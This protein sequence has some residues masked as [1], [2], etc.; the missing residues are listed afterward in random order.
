MLRLNR[1]LFALDGLLLIGVALFL[2]AGMEAVPFHGDESTLIWLS[3]D[4]YTIVHE[5]NPEAVIFRQPPLDGARQWNRVMTGAIAP[6]T[7]GLAW[8]V[9]GFTPAD[10]N[11]PWD[12]ENVRGMT[13]MRWTLNERA[14]AL[15][16]PELLRAARFP[17]TLFTAL[18]A[19]FLLAIV[20]TLTRELPPLIRHPAAWTA[21]LLYST[22]PAVLVNGRRAMQEGAMLCFTALVILVALQ[23]IR[24]IQ[25]PRPTRRR[26][27]GWLILLGV[28][29][30]AAMASKHTSALAF[31]LALL[32]VGLAPL[33][34]RWRQRVPEGLPLNRAHVFGVIG[35]GCLG[36]LVFGLLMPVWWFGPHLLV[37]AGLT[38]IAFT[39]SLGPAGLRRWLPLGA[40][41]LAIFAAHDA[42]PRV[43]VEIIGL[44]IYL[45][46]MRANLIA[47]QQGQYLG[48]GDQPSQGTILIEEAFFAPAE[49]YEDPTWAVFET[50]TAQIAAYEASG[51]AGV[52]GPV[53]GAILIG[54]GLAGLA[55]GL[56]RWRDGGR[57]LIAL[58]L[59]SGA[60]VMFFTPLPWQR[61]YLILHAPLAALAGPG[62][63]A[64]LA[65]AVSL[66]RPAA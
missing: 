10:L 65:G 58:W 63:A 7:M 15:P 1:L 45:G 29:G 25:G 52:S 66:R 41:A 24:V 28:A 26:L 17:S 44:P 5:H 23:A 22:S 43:F 42:A 9:A 57:W 18:S 40:A 60:G 6:L 56:R 62:L 61:Y 14:G 34:S 33:L 27:T 36:V 13:G 47:S 31:G 38:L 16:G 11:A 49:Y 39:L 64:L 50:T 20:L 3:R 46:E 51:L 4:Y 48:P 21:A 35:A 54:L 53:R 30:G 12:W 55:A 37:M 32:V 8:D 59:L 19:A 2:F